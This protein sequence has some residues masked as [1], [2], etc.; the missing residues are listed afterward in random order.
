MSVIIVTHDLGVAAQIAD[1]VAVMYAGR[2][3]EY[4]DARDV[5]VDPAHPY[6]IGL[7]ASTVHG[8]NRDRD[9][10][11]IPGSPPDLR[12]LVPGCSFRPRCKYALAACANEL[13]PAV[14]M[15]TGS[16]ACCV[17]AGE[18]ADARARVAPSPVSPG[19]IQ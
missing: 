14:A 11:A 3:V 2:I 17:R 12:R 10:E 13:P 18:L 16:L 6:T 9:I 7:L 8:Q 4:G 15:P 1:K 19:A 5:L